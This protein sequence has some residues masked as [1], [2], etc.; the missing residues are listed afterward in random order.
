MKLII[1]FLSVVFCSASY[2]EGLM[3]NSGF[4]DDDTGWYNW[5]DG[6]GTNRDRYPKGMLKASI[7]TQQRIGNILR[8][9]E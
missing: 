6:T 2:A 4:E 5:D 3:M 1:V 7:L 9:A 8:Q